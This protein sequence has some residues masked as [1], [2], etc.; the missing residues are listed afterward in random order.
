MGIEIK[1]KGQHLLKHK[2]Q[3]VK[4]IDATRPTITNVKLAIDNLYTLVGGSVQ[5]KDPVATKATLPLTGN[6]VNDARIVEDDGDAKQAMYACKATTGDVDAQWVKIADV[7]W[8]DFLGYPLLT[9][10]AVTGLTNEVNLGALTT[11]LLKHT[12]AGGVSTPATAIAGTDYLYGGLLVSLTQETNETDIGGT[13]IAN[14]TTTITGIDTF[15]LSMVSP[16]DRISLSS[17][18]NEYSIVTAVNSNTEL[19]VDTSRGNGTSQTINL[20]HAVLV[21]KNYAGTPTLMINDYGN[22]Y[23][24]DFNYSDDEGYAPSSDALTTLNKNT[25]NC[26]QLIKTNSIANNNSAYTY[27][28]AGIDNYAKV[29]LNTKGGGNLPGVFM[30][31]YDE[32]PIYIGTGM[33]DSYPSTEAECSLKITNNQVQLLQNLYSELNVGLGTNTKLS[34]FTVK[35]ATDITDVRGTTTANATTTINGSGTRFLIDFGIGDRISLSSAAGTYATITAIATDISLTVDTVLGDGSSQTINKKASIARFENAAG[36]ISYIIDDT[37]LNKFK[38]TAHDIYDAGNSGATKTIDWNNGSVQKVTMTDNCTFTFS[39][40]VAGKYYKLYLIQDAGGTNTHT[41]TGGG[42]S[43]VW[44]SGSEPVW[45]TTGD[46]VNIAMFD[47]YE[48]VWRGGAWL[49]A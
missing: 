29:G 12:V 24:G 32:I 7:D 41:W 26:Y 34:K 42:L 14:S 47:Y 10:Q 9:N 37:G 19:I 22:L 20:K 13:T 2:S 3:E 17:N 31:G 5:W 28:G 48:S 23:I 15:F 27:Y 6:V 11:G 4:H 33:I 35:Q 25:G 18:S 44:D 46:A 49:S 39:N 45:V 36:A 40:P 43:I 38:S 21:S 30:F 8:G 1:H 16:G